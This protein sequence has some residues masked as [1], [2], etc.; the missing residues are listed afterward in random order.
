MPFV[1]SGPAIIPIITATTTAMKGENQDVSKVIQ[2][3][4]GESKRERGGRLEL[5]PIESASKRRSL[6]L[7]FQRCCRKQHHPTYMLLRGTCV[8]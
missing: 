6:F 2:I 1:T 4:A 5:A 3:K 7:S 8:L